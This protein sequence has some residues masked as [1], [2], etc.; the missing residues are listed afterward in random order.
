MKKILFLFVI[1]IIA[2]AFRAGKAPDRAGYRIKT[3]SHYPSGE[4]FSYTYG[5]DGHLMR[6]E[7]SKGN[8]TSYEYHHERILRKYNDM[9]KEHSFVDTLIL[10]E[11]GLAARIVSDNRTVMAENREFNPDNYMT[12]TILYDKK[13][14][15]S[16][17]MVYQYQNGNEISYTSSDATGGETSTVN[18]DYYTD[19]ANTIGDD[20]MGEG[21]VGA[22]SVN[23]IKSSSSQ[24]INLAP[25][26]HNYNYHYDAKGLISVQAGYDS[27]S[28]RLLDSICYTYY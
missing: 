14:N 9:I 21:F 23:P 16:G 13:G 25:V 20:N 26:R 6:I 7:D 15:L 4:I 1:V 27:P 18:Y 28:G 22:S 8:N 2:T 12:R 11:Q 24:L 5:P 17:T 3:V 10:N 19:H